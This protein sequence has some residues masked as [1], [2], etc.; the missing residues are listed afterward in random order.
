MS[1]AGAGQVALS[2][3]LHWKVPG[4]YMWQGA[5]DRA[6]SHNQNRAVKPSLK[7]KWSS[8]A[9]HLDG[10]QVGCSPELHIWLSPAYTL[11]IQ[12]VVC[13]VLIFVIVSACSTLTLCVWAGKTRSQ[14]DRSACA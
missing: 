10:A 12:Q 2:G 3:A 6:P 1:Q 8:F 5:V 13:H 11:H 14:T 4:L 9:S 7:R